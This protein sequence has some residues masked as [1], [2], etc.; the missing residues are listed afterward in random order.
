MAVLI[1]EDFTGAAGNIVG[2]LPAIGFAGL[3]WLADSGGSGTQV[4][5]DGAG[6]ARPQSVASPDTAGIADYG[7]AGADYGHPQETKI[8]FTMRTGSTVAAVGTYHHRGVTITC[9]TAGLTIS[10]RL[11]GYFSGGVMT[12]YA[13]I[14]GVDTFV[15]VNASIAPNTDYTGVIEILNGAQTFT[16]LGAV[17]TTAHPFT[18]PLGL[19][20][21]SIDVGGYSRIDTLLVESYVA[22][23][24]VPTDN[25]I[26]AAAP[27]P[28]GSPRALV[29]HDF[30]GIMG[31]LQTVYVMD[32]QTPSGAVRVPISSWQATLQTGGANYI[33]CVIPACLA[34]IE[35]LSAATEFVIY[36]RAVLPSG[37]ALEY[38][39]ARAPTGQV[40]FDRGAQR[41]TCTLSGYSSA[42]AA[43]E[44]PPAVYDRSLTGLRSVSQG[45]TKRVRCAV[46]WLLRPGHRA[47][48]DGVPMVVRYINYYAPTG[49]DSYMDVGE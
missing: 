30:S 6:Y 42:F 12:W 9:T 35:T 31:D 43:N 34:W 15:N 36:R 17:L 2:H 49:F 33:Q 40:Q 21:V 5:L 37:E 16:I 26:R 27:S 10:F 44:N 47:F 7:V 25:F 22:A 3:A 18:N 46:D 24:V 4:H 20:K 23:P 32:L 45:T 1:S 38:E 14:N 8:T 11:W 41:Y 28:L 19:Q 13:N 29:V 39:M 48:V